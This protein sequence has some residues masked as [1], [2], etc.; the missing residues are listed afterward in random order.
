MNATAGA[1]KHR[2]FSLIVASGYRGD[3]L[4]DGVVTDSLR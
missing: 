4:L 2:L 3:A 1:A